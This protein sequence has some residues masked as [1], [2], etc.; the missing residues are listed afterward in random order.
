MPTSSR[1]SSRRL[2]PDI[3][4]ECVRAFLE[5][6]DVDPDEQARVDELAALDE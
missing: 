3:A 2:S 6:A 5:T 1:S 4:V